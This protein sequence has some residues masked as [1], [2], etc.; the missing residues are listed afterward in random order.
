MELWVISGPPGAGKSTVAAALLRRLDPVPALLDKD[1]LYGGFAGEILR[2]YGRPHGEREGP[3]YDEHVKRHEYAGMTRLA[4]EIR[5]HG[6]PVMLDGPFTSQVHSAARWTEWVEAL[7]GP[8]VRLVWVRSDAATLRERLAARGL[9]RDAGKLAAFDDYL[10]AIRVD[11]PP[12]V[13]HV[14]IDN[15]RG[16][17]PVE[18]AVEALAGTGCA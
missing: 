13:P 7:G 3:W 9:P 11:E 5:S 17:P 2:A 10:R 14:E 8:P 16:A 15:R 6:C 18:A 12:V 1:T 4:R